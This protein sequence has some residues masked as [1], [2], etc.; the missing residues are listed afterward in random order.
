MK[1]STAAFLRLAIVL[2]GLGALVLMLWEPHLEGRN[3]HATVFEIYFEDPFLAY[4]Y[5]ASIPF[6]VALHRGF[7]ALGY[8]GQEVFSRAA[9][10]ALR[11][12]RSCAIAT[13]GFVA[14]GEVFIM[15]SESDDRA[16]GVFVGVLIIFGSIVVATGAARFE[17]TVQN[18]VDMK[19]GND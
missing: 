7:K 10:K 18:A 2:I 11:T 17:R 14:V 5:L 1:R 15:M 3:A 13:I 8:A 16:G 12:T 6:F 4:A 9:V 19:S